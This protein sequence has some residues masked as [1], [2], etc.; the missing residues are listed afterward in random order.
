MKKSYTPE[1]LKDTYTPKAMTIR[2]EIK[3]TVADFKNGAANAVRADFDGV[4]IHSS[5][6]HCLIINFLVDF[7]CEEQMSMAVV[8]KQMSFLFFEVLDAVK[9]T[10]RK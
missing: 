10:T 4:E 9:F 1:G 2:R 3:D 5:N 7:K 6:G 8:S